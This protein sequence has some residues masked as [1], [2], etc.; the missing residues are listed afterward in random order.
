MDRLLVAIFLGVKRLGCGFLSAKIK[1][2]LYRPGEV[3]RVP[4]V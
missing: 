3:L 1:Q 2:T 4:G